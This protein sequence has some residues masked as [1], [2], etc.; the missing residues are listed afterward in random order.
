MNTNNESSMRK[1]ANPNQQLANRMDKKKGERCKIMTSRYSL[2]P[3]PNLNTNGI[4]ASKQLSSR[5]VITGLCALNQLYIQREVS[6]NH[7]VFQ[8]PVH[9]PAQLDHNIITGAKK[10]NIELHV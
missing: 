4:Y 9:E 10:L 5:N 2:L 7:L 8:L 6:W 1:G 3:S